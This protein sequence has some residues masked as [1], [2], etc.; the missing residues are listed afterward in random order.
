MERVTECMTVFSGGS[1]PEE[2]STPLWSVTETG[3]PFGNKRPTGKLVED[4]RQE[5]SE[6]EKPPSALGNALA[7]SESIHK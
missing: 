7:G 1:V 4:F 5:L 3:P 2:H 6:L